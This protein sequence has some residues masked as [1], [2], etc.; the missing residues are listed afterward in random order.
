MLS[1]SSWMWAWLGGVAPCLW[2]AR[3]V[4]WASLVNRLIRT[5][6]DKADAKDL[7]EVLTGLGDVA[8]ALSVQDRPVADAE[9]PGQDRGTAAGREG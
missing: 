7:P 5:V 3:T 2:L 8:R 9:N 1:L 6:V 4:V